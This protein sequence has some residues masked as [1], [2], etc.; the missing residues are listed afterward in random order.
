MRP[1]ARPALPFCVVRRLLAAPVAVAARAAAVR[2]TDA[3]ASAAGISVTT[4]A[5]K[6]ATAAAT[7]TGAWPVGCAHAA[8]SSTSAVGS[9]TAVCPA[10]RAGAIAWARC[11]RPG[12]RTR[13]S[14]AC[15]VRRPGAIAWTRCVRPGAHT[16]R[17]DPATVVRLSFRV[18][19]TNRNRISQPAGGRVNV[20]D[21]HRTR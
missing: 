5:T 9:R 21:A 6:A 20:R 10:R 13:R 18:G 12:A 2:G 3:A 11:V 1:F 17:S 4:A 7:M 16:R 14:A 19:V 15:P 8:A